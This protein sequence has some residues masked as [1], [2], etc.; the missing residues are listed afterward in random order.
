MYCCGP[1]HT[2][3]KVLDDQQEHIY[4]NS[5]PIQD[6]AWKTCQE[7]WTIEMDG[8]RGSG[9]SVLTTW[10]DDDDDFYVTIIFL[11][12]KKLQKMIP[13][14]DHQIVTKIFSWSHCVEL[15][16]LYAIHFRRMSLCDKKWVVFVAQ[17]KNG[18]DFIDILLVKCLV[19]I[20]V[21]SVVLRHILNSNNKITQI[22]IFLPFLI[23]TVSFMYFADKKKIWTLIFHS[24]LNSFL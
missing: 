6:V 20:P 22:C 14:A 16:W 19:D 3:E 15:H 23:L 24:S 11:E 7:R 5:M 8:E 10:H 12:L 13:L 18:P 17:N 9:K 4:S 21:V 2:D 1:L